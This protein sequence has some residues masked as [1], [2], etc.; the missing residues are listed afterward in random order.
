MTEILCINPGSTTTKIAL[1][2]DKNIVFEHKFDHNLDNKTNIEHRLQL[3]QD[4]LK[5]NNVTELDAVVGRG[6]M[7]PPIPSG[8]YEIN[9]KMLEDL[10]VRPQAQHAS[11][12][13][14][15][16]ADEIAKQ[17]NAKAYIVDPVTTDE[18]LSRHKITGFK[19]IKRYAAWH[20][21]NQKAVSREYAASLGKQYE[22]LNLIVAH[23][24]G[25]SSFGA[26]KKGLTINVI[27]A[28]SGEGP[29]TPERS[30]AIPAQSLIDLC[31]SG[32][33]TKEELHKK[34]AGNGGLANLLGTKDVYSLRQNYDNLPQDTKD[35]LDEMTYGI[36]RAISSLIPDFDGEKIDQ[37]LITGGLAQWPLITDKIQ[38]LLKHLN[39]S[40]SVYPGEKELEALRD[41]GIRVLG[42]KEQS[43]EYK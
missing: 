32:Q 28:L 21:L 30:G 3:I 16:L 14:A 1:Y 11:N 4:Y 10:I 31:F 33:F 13:G 22:D 9:P 39:I 43:K 6:G 15:P 18:I 19:E 38:D 41:A 34:V 23:I 20:C 37:I 5:E 8:T 25:G 42:N 40:I 27:N 2:K 24:G 12:L 26:H 17:F 36:S 7:L 29:F 35:I